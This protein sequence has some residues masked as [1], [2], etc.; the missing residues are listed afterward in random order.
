MYRSGDLARLLPNGEIEYLG[1]IDHQVKIRGYRIELGEIESQLMSHPSIKEAVVIDREN[2]QG[3]KTLVAYYVTT[4]DVTPSQ[5]K[6]HLSTRLPSYMVPSFYSVIDAIPLT[7]NGKVDRKALP[8]I[9]E[10]MELQENYV[11]PSTLTEQAL[12]EIWED[13]LGVKNIGTDDNFFDLG[14]HSLKVANLAST[15]FKVLNIDLPIHKIFENPTIRQLALILEGTNETGFNEISLAP[16]KEYYEVSSSQKRLLVIDQLEEPNTSY[17]MPGVF[18]IEGELD[19]ERFKEAF[20]KL[21]ERHE[22]LRTSFEFLDGKPIQRIHHAPKVDIEYE[23]CHETSSEEIIKSFIRP[24]QLDKA[25]LFRVKLLKLAEEKHLFLFDMHHIISD[26]ISMNIFI[27]EFSDLYTG[28]ELSTLKL[29]YKD[30][31][32]WQNEMLASGSFKDQ[33]EYWRGEFSDTVPVLELPTDFPRPKQKSNKGKRLTLEVGEELTDDL[34]KL[35]A[36]TGCTLYMTLLAAYNVLLH[37]YTGQ[38]DIVVGT[39]VVGR[40]HPDLQETIGMF[41]NTLPLRNKPQKEKTFNDFLKEVK[42]NSLKA[43]ENQDYPFEKIVDILAG[44]VKHGTTPI[45]NTLFVMVNENMS[46]IESSYFKINPVPYQTNSTQFDITLY[47]HQLQNNIV[48]SVDYSTELFKE[49]KVE[50]LL[51][52]FKELLY[53]IT[54]N[55]N[56]KISSLNFLS[57]DEKDVILNQFNKNPEELSDSSTLVEWLEKQ[58]INNPNKVAVKYNE[59][60]L[61]FDELNKEANQL[62]R[63]LTN[64]K[65]IQPDEIIGIITD[66]SKEMLIGIFAILKT[67]AAYLPVNPVFPDE[68]IEYMLNDSGCS[69]ILVN[70]SV[71][72]DLTFFNGNIININEIPHKN[73][74]KE[75]INKVIKPFHLAYVIYTSG[76]TGMPKGVMI[77]HRSV[78]NRINWMNKKYPIN[79]NDVIMQKTP[80]TFDVSVWEIFWWTLSGSKVFL[81]N[82]DEEKYP[83]QVT[84]EIYKN[85]VTTMHFVPSMLNAFLSF[86][87]ENSNELMK[88]KSLKWVFVSGEA[89]K[90]SHVVKFEKII[91]E[92]NHDVELI[93]LYGPTEATVDVSYFDTDNYNSFSYNSVP[94]GKPIDNLQLY[95]LNQENQLQPIGV[96]GE[97]CISGIGVG[98]GYINQVDLTKEKFI[99]NPI[100]PNMIL[101]KTGDIGRWL[102][103]GNIEYLGRIDHQ[104][105]IRGYRIELGEIESNLVNCNGVDDCVVIDRENENGDKY[106]CAYVVSKQEVSI[107]DI[108][109]EL[110]LKLPSYSVPSY[111]VRLDAI[112]LTPNGKAD[113]K[114]LPEPVQQFEIDTPFVEPISNTEKITADVW[115]SVLGVKR[116]GL[117]DNYFD[118]GGDSIKSI[119]IISK[120]NKAFGRNLHVSDLYEKSTVGEISDLIEKREGESTSNFLKDI[121]LKF[122]SLKERIEEKHPQLTKET[123]DIFPMSDIELGMVYH[124]I[125]NPKEAIYH[126]QFVYQINDNDFKLNIFQKAFE[127]M[128]NKHGILRTSFNL[129]D[130]EVPVQLVHKKV[131]TKL[132]V[133]NLEGLEQSEQEDFIKTHLKKDRN[134]PFSPVK[135]PLWRIKIYLLGE[136]YICLTWSFHH[137]IMDGWSVA[138]FFT[139]LS[140]TYFEIKNNP[141]Y[142]LENLKSNYKDYVVEQFALKDDE[143]IRSYWQEELSDYKVLELPYVEEKN[144]GEVEE[145]KVVRKLDQKLIDNLTKIAKELNSD[146]KS[147]SF[148]AYLYAMHMVTNEKDLTIGVVENN[149]PVCEDSDRIIGCFLNTVPVRMNITGEETWAGLINDTKE[150]LGKIKKYGRISLKEIKEMVNTVESPKGPIFNSI[151]NY[152]DFYIYKESQ[153]KENIKSDLQ[154]ENYE[155]T[156]IPIELLFSRTL[157]KTFVQVKSNSNFMSEEQMND[158]VNHF[159]TILNKLVNN[160]YTGYIKAELMK[161]NLPKLIDTPSNQTHFNLNNIKTVQEMFR[162]QV[163]DN[164][165]KVAV[166]YKNKEV[167]YREL[168]IQSDK[169]ACFLSNEYLLDK[170]QFVGVMLE[171]SEKY[172]VAILGILK[173][174]GAFLPID[175]SLPIN[176]IN[177]MIEDSNSKGIIFEKTKNQLDPGLEGRY[178]ALEEI[179]NDETFNEDVDITNSLDDAAYMI[180]TSGTTGRPKGV[181]IEQR[182]LFNFFESMSQSLKLRQIEKMLS[183]TSIS[184]DISILEVLWTIVNGIEVVLKPDNQIDQ[185]YDSYLKHSI[186]LL[187]TT[188]SRLKLLIEDK[189]SHCFLNNLRTILIGG[190][191]LSEKV[192][193]DL[194][195]L[196]N[197]ELFNLYG[198][199]ETTIWSCIYKIEED[200]K[201]YIGKP[202]LNTKVY[203]LDEDNNPLPPGVIG[204][205]FISG[206]G[207][208]RGYHEKVELTQEKFT[209]DPFCNKEMYMYNT[210]D[211]AVLLNNGNLKFIG[212]KDSSQVKLRGYRIELLEIEK[213]IDSYQLVS[214]SKVI[215]KNDSIKAFLI[216]EKDFD[217]NNLREYLTEKLPKYMLPSQFVI[218]DSFPLTPNGKINVLELE[219]HNS[220]QTNAINH[221][222]SPPVNKIQEKIC[223]IYREV[224]LVDQISIKESFFDIGGD[225]LKTISVLSKINH[226]FNVNIPLIEFHKTSTVEKIAN[227]VEKNYKVYR[228]GIITLQKGNK[229]KFSPLFLIHPH[230]GGIENYYELVKLLDFTEKPVYG[231]QAFGYETEVPA[232]DSLS[233]MV[234]KYIEEMFTVQPKGPYMIAGW[235]LGGTIAYEIAKQLERNG[236]TVEYLGLIDTHPRYDMNPKELNIKSLLTRYG[237]LLNIDSNTFNNV[238]VDE[239][240]DIILEK[241]KAENIFSDMEDTSSLRRKLEVIR[242]NEV[243]M[244]KY[245]IEGQVSSDVTLYHVR[246]F[247]E[248][249]NVLVSYEDWES[250]TTGKLKSL[251]IPGNHQNLMTQPYVKVLAKLLKEDLINSPRSKLVNI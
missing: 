28:K 103:D 192:I 83:E 63:L 65:N 132:Q 42:E 64:E 164:P 11:A 242:A 182:N 27:K 175:P 59:G 248:G 23:E 119:S 84:N 133:E 30:F 172:L 185:D 69:L 85:K 194:R 193:K 176:R 251:V 149:R 159:Y 1:R 21:M 14:G 107:S 94:I 115:Q 143:E 179:L 9:S 211:L 233:K 190:E 13:V 200:N 54:E 217:V 169:V 160:D 93:N 38:D 87:E 206:L 91:K 49:K 191:Q 55:R 5:V 241:G 110:S 232:I 234:E 3:D 109:K 166:N 60:I 43:F 78:I 26:G 123:E 79:G 31:S 35:A 57:K 20:I 144:T 139:E 102:E 50:N 140:N 136:G 158:L 155:K 70:R 148:M 204:N 195:S 98:R 203:L 118:L 17:N 177:H 205:V 71:K 18:E 77:E 181:I 10:T 81:L 210:G 171:K 124:S 250:R 116:V 170:N 16:K 173:A 129:E 68:R 76:S 51:G 230:N 24:F 186:T 174:G 86:L 188:P 33:E 224:L 213:N 137:A 131:E 6:E 235:S 34:K 90:P 15:I 114:V 187:Q 75:N 180:Y 29:Q 153:L 67:G 106:L 219:K 105:K 147:I 227:L 92:K 218:L 243:I 2:D 237:N 145:L 146:L 22:S 122:T 41:V 117:Q 37:K 97:I 246:E 239:G 8:E 7:S 244:N 245:S 161:E 142:R 47:I 151:F 96:N 138:S 231:I 165:N 163:K 120:L 184:F 214:E 125:A 82:K 168:D 58:A 225:S 39:P 134:E 236:E 216:T 101:Y 228:D 223:D 73:E 25:P 19:G 53:G 198:P 222:Y 197:A 240:F 196:T 99:R 199:T 167:T 247:A 104:V 156:E 48:F 32:E 112:P 89:L 56:G 135:A 130:Y 150:K 121:Q 157:N 88:L 238:S 100:N 66:R 111:F 44:K 36:D 208:G 221:Y 249:L 212:R 154:L 45:F 61:T 141:E 189:N 220:L 152:V 113:R 4:N 12:V 46:N 229:E 178:I 226:T 201:N 202:L 209:I 127:E 183:V 108:K 62:A 40:S 215:I 128:M 52:N 95:I 72:E 162:Q 80:F 126:D 207:V 74:S